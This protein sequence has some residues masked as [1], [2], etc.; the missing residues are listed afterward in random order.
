[1]LRLQEDLTLRQ[2][3]ISLATTKTLEDME[4]DHITAVLNELNR[5]ID[6]PRGGA[7]VLGIN[8]STLRTRMAKLGIQ[9]PNGAISN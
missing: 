1:V 5:R 6:G 9:K 8:P 2:T 4:R 7:R 3:E